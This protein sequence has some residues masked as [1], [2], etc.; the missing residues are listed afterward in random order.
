[1]PLSRRY[2][3]EHPPGESCVFGLDFSA[4]IPVGVGIGSGTLSILTNTATP[5]NDKSWTIG[6]VGV[7]GR[8]L[9]ATLTGGVSG[10]DYQLQWEAIDTDG[11][12]WPRTCLCLCAPTS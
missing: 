3:P 7:R 1:M 11:N 8:V 9:Y 5:A 2:T 10:T 4:V 6:P 12:I